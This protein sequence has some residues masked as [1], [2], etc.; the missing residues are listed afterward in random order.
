MVLRSTGVG[1]VRSVPGTRRLSAITCTAAGSCLAVGQG[2]RAAVVVDVAVD[3]T[4]R[5]VRSV[6]DAIELFDVAC[7]TNTTCV[8]T[9]RRY[10]TRPPNTDFPAPPG[11]VYTVI[12]NGVPGTAQS[13]LRGSP[14]FS[15]IACPTATRCLAVAHRAI[16]VLT[17]GNEFWTSTTVW[18]PD[19]PWTGYPAGAISCP[20]PARCYATAVAWVQT[21]GGHVAVP[22]IMTVSPEGTPGPVQALTDRAGNARAISCV[23]DGVCTV[24]GNDTWAGEGL[25]IDVRP[26]SP[27]VVTRW[28]NA[29]WFNGV[30]CL[31]ATVCGIVGGEPGRQAPVFAWRS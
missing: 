16:G 2:G 23:A 8:A 22:G 20:S 9:G 19:T 12:T 27:P 29:D 3:G 18:L 31:T 30:S 7:P 1:P 15:G 21:S 6:P 11:A 25:V 13:Y 14:E 24:V 5:A 28:A 10:T 26:G 4:P 17:A